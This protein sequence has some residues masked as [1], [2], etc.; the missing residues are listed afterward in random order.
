MVDGGEWV[1]GDRVLE[2]S[3][4]IISHASCCR[5][6]VLCSIG[7]VLQYH[8]HHRLGLVD[9]VPLLVREVAR[10]RASED[11]ISGLRCSSVVSGRR[12]ALPVR[13][14]EGAE[15]LGLQLQAGRGTFRLI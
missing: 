8:A 1:K 3:S 2:L 10:I 9:V 4:N 12:R 7:A 13:D 11:A 6:V 5:A 14:R 15:A